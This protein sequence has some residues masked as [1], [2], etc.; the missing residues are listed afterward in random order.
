MTQTPDTLEAAIE[1]LLVRRPDATDQLDQRARARL[2]EVLADPAG[3]GWM[4]SAG[5]LDG[6]SCGY[7]VSG[8]LVDVT[9]DL[10]V[11]PGAGDPEVRDRLLARLTQEWADDYVLCGRA[12]LD[13]PWRTYLD[14]AR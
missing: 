3:Q 7:P 1:A 4:E 8:G 10:G 13:R 5:L 6:D 2:A 12:R 11:L 9:G 14:D